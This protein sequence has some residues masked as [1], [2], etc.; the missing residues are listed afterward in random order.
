MAR[1]MG[2]DYGTKRC[3]VAATDILQ[4]AVHGLETLP[5][6]ELWPFLE[7][8]LNTEQVEKIV[9][10]HPT[11]ADG[12]EVSFM[13]QIIGLQRKIKKFKPEIEVVLH[14]E[15]FSSAKAKQ[16]ILNS[17]VGQNKRKDK[18]LV[19]KIAAILILQDYLKHY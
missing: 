4:I 11:H 3:G 19:D 13:N 17:G 7:K 12:N 1:I 8:Y 5:S 6:A 2:I 16:V 10:G 14:D 18:S 9:I 15:A